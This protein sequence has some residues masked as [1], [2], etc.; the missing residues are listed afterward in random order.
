[1]TNTGTEIAR[2][3][4]RRLG[5]LAPHETGE[6]A[7]LTTAL[8]AAEDL[9]DTWRAERLTLGGVVITT[10]SLATDTQDYTIGSGG[11]FDQAWPESIRAW[12]V[13]PD[14][15]V[16]DPLELPMG[17]PLTWRQWQAVAIKSTGGTHPT[18][19]FFDQEWAAGLGTCS[20]Y[21]V[22]D[23]ANVDVKLYGHVPVLTALA[24]ST[25][26]NL[27][28]AYMRA[29]KTNLAME[30]VAVLGLTQAQIPATLPK[31]ATDALAT[32]KRSNKRTPRSQIRPEYAAVGR[33]GRGRLLNV[34]T[35]D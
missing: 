21:P 12:S 4:L 24:A 7:D 5:I 15:S 30:L 13:I 10:H 22:P 26:Y 25:S 8:E 18:Q 19:M 11:D 34:Y 9:L 2:A 1:M 35:G 3:A 31:A 23:N 17:R 14:D 32:L 33:R 6:S 29:L 20:F 28:P 27:R 16:A